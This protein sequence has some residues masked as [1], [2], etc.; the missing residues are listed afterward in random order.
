MQKQSCSAKSKS[1]RQGSSQNDSPEFRSGKM[2]ILWTDE[3]SLRKALRSMSSRGDSP[4][5]HS[6]MQE[7]GR[8]RKTQEEYSSGRSP[9]LLA[10]YEMPRDGSQ[11][12]CWKMS[13]ACLVCV[14]E[15][16]EACSGRLSQTSMS[17]GMVTSDGALWE[18][19]MPVRLTGGNGFS[20]LPNPNHS[21]PTPTGQDHIERK[22]TSSEALNFDTNKSVTL[23]RYVVRWPTPTQQD[24]ENDGGPSQEVL[25]QGLLHPMADE[26]QANE[27]ST[28][29]EVSSPQER[30]VREVRINED[31]EYTPCELRHN[32]QQD[33]ESDDSLP[34]V[35]H[36]VALGER[37]GNREEVMPNNPVG[38][39]NSDWVE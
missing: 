38:S 10:R 27:V 11:C 12:S 37:K 35:P 5:S 19:A 2:S 1:I 17:W 22:C 33:G 20:Y 31:A 21:I 14:M 32:G 26:G 28:S 18:L 39:L 9:V 29:K 34:T 6:V 13:G 16:G 7:S 4:A 3:S 24:G 25:Q 15:M 36:E 30:Q 23:D 8:E